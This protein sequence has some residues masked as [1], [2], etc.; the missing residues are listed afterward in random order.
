MNS[1]DV[2]DKLIELFKLKK[3]FD[4]NLTDD[5]IADLKLSELPIFSH[6]MTND[7]NLKKLH[8]DLTGLSLL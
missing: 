8:I 3:C 1:Q 2:L 4:I 5:E 7:P 6:S